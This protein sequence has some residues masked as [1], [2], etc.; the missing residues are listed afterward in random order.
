V[1]LGEYD[2]GIAKVVAAVS[3][4]VVAII[5]TPKDKGSQYDEDNVLS[6]SSVIFGTGIIY[7]ANGYI[8]TNAHVVKDMDKIVVVLSN[9]KSYKAKVKAIDEEVDLASIKIDKGGLKVAS[10]GDMS[11]ITE[12]ESVIAIGT[13]LSFSLRNSVTEGII[14]G[15]NRSDQ[16]SYRLI[17]SDTAINSGN[18]GGP[19]M[20]L[21]GEVIGINSSKYRGVGIEGLSFSIP[22]D[23][24]RYVIDQFEQYGKVKRPYLGVDFTEGV[25]ARYGLPSDEGITISKVK[26]DSAAK[27]EGLLVD[28]VVTKVNKSKIRSITDYNEE[29]KKYLPG[30]KVTL[31]IVRDDKE[32]QVEVVY[33]EKKE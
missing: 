11:S 8:M 6:Y 12:G 33:E 28:D 1:N 9:G 27:K 20:N 32:I 7:R 18:S 4:S 10:F 26:D 24:V 29:L 19:L 21:D 31:T 17:Q 15:L 25:A 5:G 3:P 2:K 16:S 30:D 23:T 22:I 13:P 14:S